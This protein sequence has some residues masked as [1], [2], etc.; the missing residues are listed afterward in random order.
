MS[1]AG[2]FVLT[3]L[4]RQVWWPYAY[5]SGGYKGC[6][7]FLDPLCFLFA[8]LTRFYVLVLY[9]RG[10]DFFVGF[11]KYPFEFTGYRTPLPHGLM[12]FLV[13]L[14]FSDAFSLS[15]FVRPLVTACCASVYPCVQTVDISGSR[16][17]GWRSFDT[18]LRHY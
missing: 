14:Q 15:S 9:A 12:I 7:A 1:Y 8:G 13:W 5:G 10:K 2:V 6:N 16:Q 3:P 17:Y 4:K 11:S 18:V